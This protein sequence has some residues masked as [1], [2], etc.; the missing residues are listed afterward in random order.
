[1]FAFKQGNEQV[2]DIQKR[3]RVWIE[4]SKNSTFLLIELLNILPRARYW[5]GLF[6]LYLYTELWTIYN[7]YLLRWFFFVYSLLYTDKLFILLYWVCIS[8]QLH[9]ERNYNFQIKSCS[10]RHRYR[11]SLW[12]NLNGETFSSKY[13][14]I[15]ARQT[16]RGNTDIC[17]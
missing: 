14:L 7:K 3:K 11:V 13:F 2:A 9:D 15:W 16:L 5:W 1:M 6:T 17:L 12:R 4:N 8:F 10:A